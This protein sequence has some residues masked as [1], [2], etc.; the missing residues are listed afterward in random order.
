MKTIRNNPHIYEINLMTWL[1]ELSRKEGYEVNLRNIPQRECRFLKELGMD[2]IWLMGIWERSPHSKKRARGEPG[3]VKESRSIFDDFKMEDITGSPYA[4]HDYTPDPTFGFI[5]DFVPN[6]TACDHHWI[7]MYPENYIHEV[8]KGRDECNE[9]FFLTDSMRGEVCIAHGKDPYFPPWTDTAQINYSN[10]KTLMAVADVLSH[11]ADYC[12]GLRCDMAMLS[13]KEIFNQTWSK[14]LK[15]PH[16]AEEFW[17]MAIE[18]LRSKGTSCLLLA[19]AYWGKE[20]DLL[21]FGFHYAYDK[22]LY[23]LLV[24]GDIQGLRNHLS[25]PVAHQQKMIR[26]LEN[27]DEPR[28]L[29]AFGRDRIKCALVVHATLPGMRFWQHGQFEG[30]RIRVPVQVRRAPLE[31]IDHDLKEFTVKLLNEVNHPVFHDGTWEMCSIEGWPDNPSHQDLLAWCWRKGE[32][33][34]LVVTNYSTSPAQGYVRLPM[35]WLPSVEQFLLSDPLKGEKFFRSK[36]ETDQ[37]GLYV[38]LE[39]SDFHFFSVEKG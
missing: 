15:E 3:L 12:H 5:L 23:D 24:A 36:T 34:R 16:H 9:G 29:K 18:R 28:A 30:N 8:P 22:T 33:R 10:P 37:S 11:L 26:F 6:H 35:N 13:L 14:Y 38:G 2:L 7:R 25:A 32:H 20:M 17:P 31:T 19:E 4:V 27:H 1:H 21:N 39:K